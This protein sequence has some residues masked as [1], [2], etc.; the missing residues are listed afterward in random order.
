MKFCPY[1]KETKETSEFHKNS[2]KSDGLQ[3]YCKS[4]KSQKSSQKYATTESVRDSVKRRHSIV[5]AYNIRFMRRYK[6]F[7]GCKVCGE[8]EPVALDLHHLDPSI[9]EYSPAQMVAF[10]IENIKRE[11][12]KCVVLCANCHRKV[13]AGILEV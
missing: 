3:N 4:C 13:H 10:N 5:K 6:R 7:C 2:R 11:F 8:R 12:R 9:K 1:C